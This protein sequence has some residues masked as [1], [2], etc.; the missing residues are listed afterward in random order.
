[1]AHR[2]VDDHPSSEIIPSEDANIVHNMEYDQAKA[3]TINSGREFDEESD[4]AVV[5]SD[6]EKLLIAPGTIERLSLRRLK[7]SWIFNM[8][9]NFTKIQLRSRY[10][11]VYRIWQ[12]FLS[13]LLIAYLLF[14]FGSLKFR[15]MKPIVVA[16]GN[17]PFTKLHDAVWEFKWLLA[18]IM[19]I[20]YFGSG[21]IE[22]FFAGISLPSHGYRK[23]KYHG[24]IYLL[25]IGLFVI[26]LPAALH[27]LQLYELSLRNKTQIY[28]KVLCDVFYTL[29]RIVTIPSFC[30]VTMVLYLIKVQI[31][32]LGQCLKYT[33]SS[34]GVP[35]AKR[36]IAT[37]KMSIRITDTKLKWYL[38][39]HMVLI[40]ITAFTG[41]FS[42]I[43]RLQITM[44]SGNRTAGVVVVSG[45]RESQQHQS[46]LAVDVTKLRLDLARLGKPVP[47]NL[48]GNSYESVSIHWLERK[49]AR[50]AALNK[51]LLNL[52]LQAISQ[53]EIKSLSPSR[54]ITVNVNSNTGPSQL[55]VKLLDKSRPFRVL[56]ESI[57]EFLEVV[58]LFLLPLMLLS[59]HERAILRITD[60]IRDL[61]TED[62]RRF[63]L[64]IDSELNQKQILKLLQDMHGVSIFGMRVQ[65]YKAAFIT[66][67]S[68]FVTAILH[69][70]FKKYG[71]Y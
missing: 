16:E 41:I 32:S 52:A 55:V 4:A 21:H 43:E 50:L 9:G 54:N 12:A 49:T 25:S 66:V 30:V 2:M 14:A 45:I 71:M 60:E 64:L 11:I 47:Q 31:D 33:N 44:Y 10:G 68:P 7:I 19:G 56:M 57:V 8:T 24:W 62:Q 63:G 46:Q 29:F 22:R 53:S 61:D 5:E 58:M 51:Q 35:Y 20:F 70:I 40:L 17:L 27:A 3:L 26:T 23:A 28:G 13:V 38:V 67:L 1:M 18:F 65:F 42:C 69:F 34:L 36:E 39:C 15:H 48:S 6:E 59:W 37:V